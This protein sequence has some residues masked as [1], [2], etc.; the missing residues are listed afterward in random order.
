MPQGSLYLSAFVWL[1][2]LCMTKQKRIRRSGVSVLGTIINVRIDRV[3]QDQVDQL[4]ISNS[5]S[6]SDVVRAAVA[7]YLADSAVPA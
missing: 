4:A 5:V 2:L 1:T 6:R 3:T 7:A